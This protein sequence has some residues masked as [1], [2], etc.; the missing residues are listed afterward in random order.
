MLADSVLPNP[1]SIGTSVGPV[2]PTGRDWIISC[3]AQSDLFCTNALMHLKQLYSNMRYAVATQWLSN[4]V[5]M[6]CRVACDGGFGPIQ[7]P[8]MTGRS[9]VVL[10]SLIGSACARF[11]W[12][13]EVGDHT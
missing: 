13:N 8:V 5:G 6:P 7:L 10:I 3:F 2:L 1:G 9:P 12:V 4:Q 11:T